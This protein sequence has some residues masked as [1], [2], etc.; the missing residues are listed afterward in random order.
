MEVLPVMLCCR[1]GKV[2][3]D[4]LQSALVRFIQSSSGRKLRSMEII[5]LFPALFLGCTICMEFLWS[6]V[7]TEALVTRKLVYLTHSHCK[8]TSPLPLAVLRHRVEWLQ[9]SPD[10]RSLVRL[11]QSTLPG[12]SWRIWHLLAEVEGQKRHK[13]TSRGVGGRGADWAWG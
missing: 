7:S 6:S 12:R 3:E 10:L 4:C 1:P 13:E 5:C 2:W 9:G 11:F 8:E